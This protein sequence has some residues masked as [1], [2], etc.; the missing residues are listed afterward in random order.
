M[1]RERLRGKRPASIEPAVL[2]PLVEA[3]WGTTVG[4]EIR[5]GGLIVRGRSC[6]WTG[7]AGFASS[8]S[9]PSVS[10]ALVRAQD[11]GHHAA[12]QRF[13]PATVEVNSTAKI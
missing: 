10:F 1:L 12:C 11:S 5:T 4:D 2:A 8:V 7:V 13:L 6:L 9:S 3:E